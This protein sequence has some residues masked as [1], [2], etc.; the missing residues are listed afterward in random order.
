MIESAKDVVFIRKQVIELQRR[1]KRWSKTE[2]A[3]LKPNPGC[4]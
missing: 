1:S 2:K 4:S 3:A